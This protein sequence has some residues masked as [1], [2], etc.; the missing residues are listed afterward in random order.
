[1]FRHPGPLGFQVIADAFAY[2]YANALL[3]ALDL[4][5]STESAMR[6]SIWPR[7]PRLLARSKLPAPVYCDPAICNL[8][9]PPGCVYYEV[10]AYGR[11]Q[12]N[13]V[14]ASNNDNLLSAKNDSG[15]FHWIGPKSEDIP[16]GEAGLP[17]CQH[18]AR[19]GAMQPRNA[20]AGWLVFALPKEM[21]VGKIFVCCW[22]DVLSAVS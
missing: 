1:M 11:A 13:I 16:R 2:L 6:T 14:P 22:Y 12:L 15:W 8:D 3:R 4:I 7:I 18:L 10:P 5:E 19:C 20:Q 21:T 9:Y 17:E